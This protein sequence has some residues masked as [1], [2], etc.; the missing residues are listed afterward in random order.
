MTYKEVA[1]KLYLK[2]IRKT[3]A[4]C[5]VWSVGGTTSRNDV[6]ISPTQWRDCTCV[7]VIYNVTIDNIRDYLESLGCEVLEVR[8]FESIR[9]FQASV[10]IFFKNYDD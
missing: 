9:N 6:T 10:M 7:D 2:Y 3:Y 8:E 1:D 5:E 4:R